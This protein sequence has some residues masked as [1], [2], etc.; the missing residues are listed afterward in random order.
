MKKQQ[1]YTLFSF[2]FL[3]FI[4]I[5]NLHAQLT[6][7]I[8]S[9]TNEPL[10][11][12]SIY[13]QGTTKGT[14][15]NEHGRY[16]FDL[17]SGD[18]KIVCQYV[19]YE[20]KIFDVKI[21]GEQIVLNIKLDKESVQ[22]TEVVIRANAED[23]AYPIIRKAIAKRNYYNELVQSYECDVYI[24]G[25]QKLLKAPEKILGQEVGDLG[26]SLD[27]TGQGIIYVSESQAKLSRSQPN[28]IKE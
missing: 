25:N 10:P 20:Q 9:K 6:G 18:Y 17:P 27:S 26:G 12:A 7:I 15:S 5:G 11:F 1:N 13:V 19:G 4:S 21:R 2:I 24:K 16:Q 22:L 14:T 8:S 3:F 23:P 28:N